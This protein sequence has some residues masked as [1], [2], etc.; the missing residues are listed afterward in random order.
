MIYFETIEPMVLYRK[1]EIKET[2][3]ISENSCFA[4]S[5]WIKITTTDGAHFY[6]SEDILK[7][8][9]SHPERYRTE[10]KRLAYKTA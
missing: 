8:M 2:E 1:H 7:E 3:V 5:A 4:V 6:T 10:R 9:N